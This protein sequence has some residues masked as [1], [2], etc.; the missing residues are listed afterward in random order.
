MCTNGPHC[1]MV[2]IFT[3]TINATVRLNKT[4]GKFFVFS[5]SVRLVFRVADVRLILM[6]VLHNLV[7][8]EAAVQIYRKAIAVNVHQDIQAKIVKKKIVIAKLIHVQRVQCAKMSLV[9]AI[10][11]AFAAAATPATTAT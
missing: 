10:S 8:T 3:I 7:S 4:N 1:S 9:T 2:R 6:S 5:V 11:H